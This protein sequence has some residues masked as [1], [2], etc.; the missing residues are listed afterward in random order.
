MRQRS[1]TENLSHSHDIT[2]F[3]PEKILG[4]LAV[5]T[6]SLPATSQVYGKVGMRLPTGQPYTDIHL[7]PYAGRDDLGI[8]AARRSMGM[9]ADYFVLH[10]DE[11]PSQLVVGLTGPKMGKLARHLGFECVNV[12]AGKLPGYLTNRIVGGMTD[13]LAVVHQSTD[14]IIAKYGHADPLLA[15]EL[16]RADPFAHEALE[17][18]LR[19]VELSTY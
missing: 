1:S 6:R 18:P 12:D 9:V 17:I 2:V 14:A 8:H 5:D 3:E 11:V 7:N 19:G 4:I 16:Y 13:T 15:A 10:P